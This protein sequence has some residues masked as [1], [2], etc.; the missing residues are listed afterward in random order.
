MLP[1]RGGEECRKSFPIRPLEVSAERQRFA[2]DS[3]AE[4][5]PKEV[6]IRPMGLVSHLPLGK[7]REE[8]GG[9]DS[10]VND[11]VTLSPYKGRL[12][13][14]IKKMKTLLEEK[15]LY[16][17]AAAVRERATPAGGMCVGV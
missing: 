9:C 5:H 10:E 3:E 2:L 17:L 14:F 1:E 6:V 7:M 12:C 16:G 11:R 15:V 8:I 13:P 4:L